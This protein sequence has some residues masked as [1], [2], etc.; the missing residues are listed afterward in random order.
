MKPKQ[1]LGNKIF[2][3]ADSHFG[4]ANIIDYMNRPFNDVNDMEIKMILNWNAK[5]G[6]TDTV[7]ILGDFCWKAKDL[8]RIREQLNGHLIHIRGNHCKGYTKNGIE[9]HDRL[10]I[11]VI[12]PDMDYGFQTIIL[13]H[14]P[15]A[16]WN[17]QDY[18]SWMIHG[19]THK[20]FVNNGASYDVGEEYTPLSY[21]EL[22]KLIYHKV[23]TPNFT[24]GQEICGGDVK[25]FE[26]KMNKLKDKPKQSKFKQLLQKMGF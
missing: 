7:F 10:E 20:A 9:I 8:K 17:Y 2:F 26:D 18:G 1:Y 21:E 19:H 22:K 25:K 5:V 23:N 4:H 12:D 6:K 16:R 3:I 15:L 13:D 14:Y 24:Y 11:R